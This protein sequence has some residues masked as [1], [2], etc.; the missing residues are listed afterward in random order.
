[1]K[2]VVLA[3][4]LFATTLVGVAATSPAI[5][6][7]SNPSIVHRKATYT[8]ASGHMNSLKS[9]LMLGGSGDM[10]YHAEGIKNAFEHMGNA[11][12]AGSDTGETKAKAEIWSDMDKFQAKGKDAYGASVAL[13]EAA[14]GGDNAATGAAFK[15]MAGACKAC[16]EDF[17]AK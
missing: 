5:A 12:P 17:K 11:F 15:K 9:I 10:V 3:A 16:H 4:S 13:V 14:K 2:T 7:E 8:V 1:M 6:E